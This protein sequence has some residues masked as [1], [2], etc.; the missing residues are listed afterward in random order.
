[1]KDA[2]KKCEDRRKAEIKGKSKHY[3][4]SKTQFQLFGCS[5]S[6]S[7][8]LKLIQYSDL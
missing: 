8:L 4:S 1:V 2:G 7:H 6:L 5:L 3:V